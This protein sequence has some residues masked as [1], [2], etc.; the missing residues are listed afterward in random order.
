MTLAQLGNRFGVSPNAVR[1]ALVAA[2]VV[3]RARWE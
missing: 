3:M 1:R 2:G